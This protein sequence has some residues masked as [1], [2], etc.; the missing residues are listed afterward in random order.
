MFSGRFVLSGIAA[1]AL[2]VIAAPA[3]ALGLGRQVIQSALGEPLRAEIDVTSITPE[4]A[5]NLQIRVAP[6]ESYK[7]AGVDYNPVLPNTQVTLA[8]RPDGRQYLRGDPLVHG[9]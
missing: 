7:A 3:S 2:S 9:W 8:K 1:A 4:E 6:P 5:N